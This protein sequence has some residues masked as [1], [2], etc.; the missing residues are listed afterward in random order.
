MKR[1]LWIILALAVLITA[2]WCT[3]AGADQNG[4]CGDN[5]TYS[6][7]SATGLLT[8]SGNGAMTDYDISS[9]LSPFARNAEIQTVNVEEGVTAIGYA[10]FYGCSGITEVSLPESLRVIGGQAFRSC[11]ALNHITLPNG[12]ESIGTG[13]F[14]FCR[15]LISVILPDSLTIIDTGVFINCSGLTSVSIPGSVVSVGGA[16]FA[17]CANLTSATF[18]NPG[19]VIGADAFANANENLTLYG[20]NPSTAKDYAD[21]HSDA[22]SFESLGS[23]SGSCGETVTYAFDPLTGT[24]TI[25]GTGNMYGYVSGNTPW[26]EHR[27]E[28]NTL[29]IEDGITAIGNNDFEDLT[30]ISQ[31]N[32]PEGVTSIGFCAFRNCYRLDSLTLPSTLTSIGYSAFA[33]CGHLTSVDIPANV[34]SIGYLAFTDCTMLTSVTINNPECSLGEDIFSG[35][36]GLTL[37]G[38]TPSTAQTYAEAAGITFE[39]F[40]SLSGSCG[41]TVAYAFDPL[42]GTLNISGTGAMTDYSSTSSAPWYS[43]R[44]RIISVSISSGVTDIGDYAFRYCTSLASVTIP[45]SVIDI[46]VSAFEGCTGLTDITIPNSVT[47]LDRY[48]FYNCISLSN[49]MIPDSVTDI[50]SCAFYYCS[51]LTSITIP[52]SVTSIGVGIFARCSNLTVIQVSGENTAFTSEDGVLYV[53]D[54]TRLVACPG[55]RTGAFTIPE[56][57]TMITASAFYGCTG[58]T[59]VTIPNGV[60]S[61]G[62]QAFYGCSGLINITIPESVTSIGF[63]AFK[64]CSGLTDVS[65]LNPVCAIGDS[66]YDVFTGCASGFTL[67]GWSGSTAEIYATAAGINFE[68]MGTYTVTGSCGENVIYTFDS[69]TGTL[70]ISGTGPMTDYSDM[71]SEP[72]YNI[73]EQIT[74]ISIG[75]GVTSIGVYAF[76]GCTGLTSVNIPASVT[77]IESNAFFECTSLTGVTIPSSATSIGSFAFY[78]CAGLTSVTIPESVTSIGFQ[79][80]KNCSGLTDVSILSPACVIN[81][82]GY[83]AFQGCASGFTLHGWSGSTAEIYATA[84]GINFESLGVYIDTG[85]CGENVTYTFNFSTGALTISGTGAMTEDYT[86]SSEVPWCSYRELIK[87]VNIESGVTSVGLFAFRYCTGL[88]SINIP[89]SVTSIGS[90]S[91]QGCTGLT[92]IIIPDSVTSI[93]IYAFDDCTG[94]TSIV[95]PDGLTSI[96]RSAFSGCTGLT[97]VTI[98]TSVTSIGIYAFYGCSSMTSVTIPTN[99]TSIGFFAFSECTGLTSVT[100]PESVT[101]IDYRAFKDCSGLTDVS[102][103]NP[104]CTIGDNYYNVF[105]GCASGFTLHGWDGSTAE[106]Y[107]AAAGI[108]FESLGEYTDTGSCGDNLTYVYDFVAGTLTISGTGTMTD[109]MTLEEQPWYSYRTKITS[110]SIGSGVTSIGTNAFA[111][112]TGL[113]SVTIP[114]SVTEIGVRAFEACT[115]LTSVIIPNSVTSIRLYAFTQCTGLTSINIPDSVTYLGSAAFSDCSSLTSVTL[116]NSLT[117]IDSYTFGGCNSLTSITIPASVTNINYWAFVNSKNLTSVT[118]LNPKC[119]IGDDDYDVFQGCASGLT[120]YGYSGSTA[121]AYAANTKNPCNFI[122]LAAPAPTFTLPAGLTAI[123]ADAFQGIA[124]E[125]ALIPAS[126]TDI[127]GNPFAGS[128]VQ[129]IFGTPGTVAET[130]ANAKGYIFVSVGE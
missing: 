75:N 70:T 89:D 82:S 119:V 68:S 10:A 47:K 66:A 124:A 17:F 105:Q 74:S 23:L 71:I 15:G 45:N 35:C 49:I 50:G 128:Q 32:I 72:W 33:E 88:T 117:T 108:N 99:V 53:K 36:A 37:Y 103:L 20:W 8:I 16:A 109:Y 63:R 69:G 39:S 41:E 34:T 77:N 58:L 93:G 18:N 102:I 3:A 83:S 25:S 59:S 104:N 87:S 86:M 127:E 21:A 112:C 5:V 62:Y 79:A 126:V 51:G 114:K 78:G 76:V 7:N 52:N 42:T 81:K 2:V 22:I 12:L 11:S 85:S 57:V 13:A 27:D 46:G 67:H 123:E 90:D 118:V 24:L 26:Y 38:W 73:R 130:F 28:I 30:Q 97:S 80:F 55:A 95:L 48:V 65:I 113:T 111:Y 96:S 94:L 129:Y 44:K 92:S 64:N 31:V 121:E 4:A 125:A 43:Y 91:F 14:S 60:T 6:F 56:S 106:T 19:T 116:P 107:A 61:I 115:G 1:K 122:A 101:S 40:G 98:P 54:K 9:N 110:L 29:I 84:A 100:I 120:L